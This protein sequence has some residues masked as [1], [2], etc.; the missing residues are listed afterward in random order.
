MTII[1]D[2]PKTDWIE[3]T[4]KKDTA[5]G[6]RRFVQAVNT[7]VGVRLASL[8]T[9][10]RALAGKWDSDKRRFVAPQLFADEL[11]DTIASLNATSEIVSPKQPQ[12]TA[13]SSAIPAT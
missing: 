11:R 3:I 5:Q 1:G 10:L 12:Q 2:D 4:S 9:G 13:K 8:L 7:D 6:E